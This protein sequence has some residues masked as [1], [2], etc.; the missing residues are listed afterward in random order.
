[1]AKKPEDLTRKEMFEQLAKRLQMQALQSNMYAYKPHLKQM[2]FHKSQKSGRLYIGGNRSGK[3][4]GGVVEDLWWATRRH[5]YRQIPD[6]PINGRILGVDFINGVQ[7]ILLPIFKRWIIP[8]DLIGGSWERSWS[9]SERTLTLSNGSILDFKSYDQDLDKHAGTSR[10][11]VHFDEEPPKAV[12]NENLVRTIDVGGAWWITMTP[13]QGLTWTYKTLY[14]PAKKGTQPNLD[15][16]EVDMSDNP[17]LSE[18]EKMVALAFL[19]DDERAKREHGRYVPRGGLVF[20]EFMESVHAV[21]PGDW[22]PPRNWLVYHSLDHGYN[23]PTASL[24]HAVSPVGDS[25]VTFHEDYGREQIIKEWARRILEWE[26][27]NKI[28]PFLRTGD[29]AMKQR[30]AQSGSSIAQLYGE[31]GILFALDSVPRDV[32]P[33]VDKINTYLKINPATERPFWQCTMGCE[34]LIREMKQLHWEFYTSPRMEDANNARETIHKKDDHA[35]DA[36]RYFFTFLPEISPLGLDLLHVKPETKTL[37]VGTVWDIP[38]MY[39]ESNFA[40]EVK[41][42]IQTG[43][44]LSGVPYD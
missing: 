41:W 42:E 25:I 44:D 29:P 28:D 11:F 17:F 7:G 39:D 37:S 22:K 31:E 2:I 19:D 38:N 34:H 21:L 14:E 30:Q 8:S 33:G 27:N 40:P 6:K 32:A 18:E 1:M 23:N 20:P 10:D 35:P 15:L 24:H 9:L 16:I 43:Y 12:F 13:V 3:S 26:M 5:P 36:L 4:V